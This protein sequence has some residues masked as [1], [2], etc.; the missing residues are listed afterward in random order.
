MSEKV[1]LHNGDW[2]VVADGAKALILENTGPLNAPRLKEV[3]THAHKSSA[4]HELG[5]DAP[6]RTHSSFGQGSSA[7]SQTDWHDQAE[8][9]FLESLAK[10][11]D[12][13]IA[14]GE[15][16]SIVIAAP[17][18][19]LHVLRAAYGKALRAAVRGEV[20]KDLVNLPIAEIQKHFD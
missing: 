8:R 15:A 14:A 4:T 11:L 5:S 6:G 16:K 20:N 17:P 13:A 12:A 2:V 19:A 18:R 3:E 10:R 1:M 9:N 7:V